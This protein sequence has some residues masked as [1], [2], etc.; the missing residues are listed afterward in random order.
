[1]TISKCTSTAWWRNP[2]EQSASL[3]K[4][5]RECMKNSHKT[6][7]MLFFSLMVWSDQWFVH[8]YLV[9]S[10]AKWNERNR[11][12]IS[13]LFCV[14]RAWDVCFYTSR[15]FFKII[16]MR[17]HGC[18]SHNSY[19]LSFWHWSVA[20]WM[21]CRM[22]I[23]TGEVRSHDWSVRWVSSGVSCQLESWLIIMEIQLKNR[24]AALMKETDPLWI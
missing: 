23:D 17:Y 22:D 11:A 24:T 10:I 6:G 9:L 16:F 2:K 5:R 20:L 1:M 4:P 12:E 19:G 14:H 21:S 3:R 8:M 13:L 7:R 18:Q 15:W